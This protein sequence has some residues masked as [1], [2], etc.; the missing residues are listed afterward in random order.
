MNQL[1][2]EISELEAQLAEH[3]EV[4]HNLKNQLTPIDTAP[5]KEKV[6]EAKKRA[7]A[8][9]QAETATRLAAK[10]EA[11]LRRL[12]LV[13]SETLSLFRELNA[14]ERE[15]FEIEERNREEMISVLEAYNAHEDTHE[16]NKLRLDELKSELAAIECTNNAFS[17]FADMQAQINMLG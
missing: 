17:T 11:S 3:A 14:A 16:A 15:L 9:K 5:L 10:T 8:S 13:K 4:M 7:I 1:R 6:A 12:R 2:T